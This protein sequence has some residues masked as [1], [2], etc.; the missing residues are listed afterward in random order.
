MPVGDCLLDNFLNGLV[1]SAD[2]YGFTGFTSVHLVPY[3]HLVHSRDWGS[4]N[5]E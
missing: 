3:L 5:V 2:R 4:L 1:H